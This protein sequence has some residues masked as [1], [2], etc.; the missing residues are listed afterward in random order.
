M[1]KNSEAVNQSFLNWIEQNSF[2]LWVYLRFE[3]LNE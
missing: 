2:S 1:S 3:I